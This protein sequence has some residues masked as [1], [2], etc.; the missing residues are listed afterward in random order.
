MTDVKGRTPT[1]WEAVERDYRAGVLSIREIARQHDTKEGTI[2]SRAK[3]RGW[4]RD[5]TAQVRARAAEKLSR[6]HAGV[7][8]DARRVSDEEAIEHGANLIDGIVRLHRNDIRSG[9]EVAEMMLAE[10]RSECAHKDLLAELAEGHVADT[11]ADQQTANVIRRAVSLPGRASTLRDLA[12][13]MQRLIALERQ[14]FNVDDDDEGKKGGLLNNVPRD[15]L[16]A[17]VQRLNG[18]LAD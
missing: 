10:L 7:H 12:Q 4:E 9:R 14:A 15:T 6:D 16:R 18:S 3:A 8:A 13:S 5:L 11:G 17:I 1:D 2:R